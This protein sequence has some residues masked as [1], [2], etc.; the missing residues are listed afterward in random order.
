MCLVES[1][2]PN[3][4]WQRYVTLAHIANSDVYFGIG[5]SL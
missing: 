5:G 2:T 1:D 3:K 4:T